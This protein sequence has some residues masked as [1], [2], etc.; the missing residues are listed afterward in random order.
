MLRYDPRNSGLNGRECSHLRSG[1]IAS[2]A[3]AE[4]RDRTYDEPDTAATAKR[5]DCQINQG[6]VADR[7]GFIISEVA[8][9]PATGLVGTLATCANAARGNISP[10]K[11]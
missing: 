9:V 2:A 10:H 5:V 1:T 8:E 4:G 11:R 3:N 6:I 7:L